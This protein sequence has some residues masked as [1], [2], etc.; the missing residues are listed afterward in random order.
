ME[1]KGL[2]SKRQIAFKL[3]GKK[4]T[5]HIIKKKKIIQFNVT[6]RHSNDQNYFKHT[7]FT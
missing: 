1:L 6:F 2:Q 5:F 4:K 7:P 3:N